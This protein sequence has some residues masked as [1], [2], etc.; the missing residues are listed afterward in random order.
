MN[1][2]QFLAENPEAVAIAALLL[3]FVFLAPDRMG[4]PLPGLPGR[5]GLSAPAPGPTLIW[6]LQP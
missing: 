3:F 5:P 2:R 4:V 1:L 6:R